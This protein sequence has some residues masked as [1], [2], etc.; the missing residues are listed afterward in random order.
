MIMYRNPPKRVMVVRLSYYGTNKCES[1]EL[2]LTITRT[3]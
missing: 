1:T 3:S 2:L